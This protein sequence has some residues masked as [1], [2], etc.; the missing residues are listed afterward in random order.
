MQTATVTTHGA[1]QSV[2]LPEGFHINGNEVFVKHVGKSV[3]LIP[4]DADPWDLMADSLG[5]FTDDF[6][7][8]RSQPPQQAREGPFA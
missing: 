1:S 8:D 6:M 7:K 5:Q 2:E 3:L 4:K